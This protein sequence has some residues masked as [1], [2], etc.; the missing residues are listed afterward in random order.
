MHK[1]SNS[2]VLATPSHINPNAPRVQL[3]TTETGFDGIFFVGLG[4]SLTW[5]SDHPRGRKGRSLASASGALVASVSRGVGAKL[6]C[7]PLGIGGRASCLR[8]SC[9]W[10]P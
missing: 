1:L 3:I 6:V 7:V 9:S 8:Y 10:F 5:G 4:G 2:H